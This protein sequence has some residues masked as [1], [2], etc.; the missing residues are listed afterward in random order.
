MSPGVRRLWPV[1]SRFRL[2]EG[3]DW[4][5][6]RE[7]SH[8]PSARHHEIEIGRPG[9]ARDWAA[10]WGCALDGSAEAHDT[11]QTLRRARICATNEIS[12]EAAIIR[13][14]QQMRAIYMASVAI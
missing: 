14:G 2:N 10:D 12:I 7:D 4:D 1:K 8:A 13:G 6:K 3:G 9:G 11:R 5:A